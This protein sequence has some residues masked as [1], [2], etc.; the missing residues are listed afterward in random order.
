MVLTR[1]D[2]Y[3]VELLK[4]TALANH[5]R[6][7]MLIS[8]HAAAGYLHAT[9]GMAVYYYQPAAPRSTDAPPDPSRS[10]NVP[11]LWDEVQLRH[12][13]ASKTLATDLQQALQHMPGSP[14]VDL[15]QAP[16]AVLAGADMPAVLVEIGYLTNPETE[17]QLSSDDTLAAYARAIA[18]GIDGYMAA[19]R[20]VGQRRGP[21]AG[22]R[23]N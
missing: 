23:Y 6:A 16:L 8:L 14:H 9:T 21:Y 13:T 18:Q 3:A 7:N 1:S 10:R 11:P 22:G 20:K 17:K 4:R 15:R 2:D 5:N 19:A 12:T